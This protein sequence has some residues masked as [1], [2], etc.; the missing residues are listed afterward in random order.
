MNSKRFTSAP[1]PSSNG[2]TPLIQLQSG[3]ELGYRLLSDEPALNRLHEM[4]LRFPAIL[5]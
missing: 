1:G 4:C 3:H 2:V 5:P